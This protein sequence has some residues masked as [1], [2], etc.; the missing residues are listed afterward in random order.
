MFTLFKYYLT[1]NFKRHFIPKHF[2]YN[3]EKDQSRS[4]GEH[5]KTYAPSFKKDPVI[6]YVHG[7]DRDR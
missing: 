5:F 7:N 4:N 3:N 6:I 2:D 1:L